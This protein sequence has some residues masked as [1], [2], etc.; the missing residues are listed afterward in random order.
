MATMARA[1]GTGG[2]LSG[3]QDVYAELGLTPVINARGNQTVLGGALLS[4]RIQAAMDAANRYFVDMEALLKQ[5]GKR[6]AELLECEAAYVTPGC[7]AALALGTAACIT[8]DDGELMERLPDT[9]GMENVAVIQARHRYKYDR[10]PTIVGAKLREAGDAQ[11]TTAAQLKEAIRTDTAV[12]LFPAHLDGREG[13]MPLAEVIE[14]A[15]AQG[16]PVLLDA[17]SQIYPVTRMRSW[18]KMGADLV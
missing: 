17:A 5:T 1:A 12:V 2:D 11:G 3:G 13:T 10:P 4:A 18:T 15:H 7:A 6:C 16:V 14:I 9:T 8:G